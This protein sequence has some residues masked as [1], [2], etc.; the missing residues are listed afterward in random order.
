MWRHGLRAT[1]GIH[2][3]GRVLKFRPA[4]LC[5]STQ[6]RPSKMPSTHQEALA[7]RSL[8]DQRDPSRRSKQYPAIEQETPF[9]NNNLQRPG[10]QGRVGAFWRPSDPALISL[11]GQPGSWHVKP[12]R[13]SRQSSVPA[14]LPFSRRTAPLR[15]LPSDSEA[16]EVR[17]GAGKSAGFTAA[18]WANLG[19]S[20]RRHSLWATIVASAP[21]KRDLG[22]R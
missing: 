2:K 6:G 20:V 9:P 14:F 18:S 19:V 10:W 13:I 22:L 15:G 4:R 21:R 5:G 7:T 3:P 16:A 8:R 1:G 11:R 17:L 12:A